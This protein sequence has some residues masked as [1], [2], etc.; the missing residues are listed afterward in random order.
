MYSVTI[1][2]DD[3]LLSGNVQHKETANG[4]AYIVRI[5][6]MRI[7]NCRGIDLIAVKVF[8]TGVS[9]ENWLLDK[10]ECPLFTLL[11]K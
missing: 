2:S 6:D 8:G 5:W 11:S 1:F 3:Q 4:S 7:C 10:L 9:A